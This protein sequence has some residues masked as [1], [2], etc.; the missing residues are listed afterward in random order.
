VITLL[1]KEGVRQED[2]FLDPLV[3]PIAVDQKARELFLE[4]LEKIKK[5]FPR[6]KTV[7]GISNISFGLP[8]RKLLNRTFLILALKAGLDA[9]IVD[10]LDKEIMAAVS[11]AEAL[12]GKDSSL[13]GYLKSIR[14]GKW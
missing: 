14:N 4:S 7:A 13:K 6:V 12:L 11:A 2:I 10:P 5:N 3:R 8:R 9:A 1:R